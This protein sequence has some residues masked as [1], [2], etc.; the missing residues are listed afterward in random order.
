MSIEI[1]IEPISNAQ[2][3]ITQLLINELHTIERMA[4]PIYHS[5]IRQH[6][7]KLRDDLYLVAETQYIDKVYRDSYYHYYS[8]KLTHQDRNAVRISLFDKK[9]VP[10][11]F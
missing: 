3:L 10:D 7:E 1:F 6:I 11:D 4:F 2:Q 8:S 9:V 5:S